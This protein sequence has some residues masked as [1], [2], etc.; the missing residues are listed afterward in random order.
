MSSSGEYIRP[1]AVK[2]WEIWWFWQKGQ[3]RLQPKKPAERIVEPGR[4]W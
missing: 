1:G 3:W 4:K 2:D